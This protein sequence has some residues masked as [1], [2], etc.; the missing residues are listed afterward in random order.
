MSE[1]RI[2]SARRII[3]MD[4]A[5]PFATHVA[6]KDGQILAVGSRAEVAGPNA[7]IDERFAD[8]I[9]VPGFVEGHAHVL[10]GTLWKHVYVGAFDR[11]N[12]EGEIVTGLPST[13][14]IIE[15]L[16]A[17]ASQLGD[18][19]TP[20]NGWGFDPLHIEGQKL[21]RHD[22]DKVST[23]RPVLVHHASLHITVVNSVLLES[24]GFDAGTNIQGVAK[25]PDGTPSGEL[26]G[27]AAR[28]R[29]ARTMGG[30]PLTNAISVGDIARFAAAAKVQGITTIT[31][32]HSE[33]TDEIVGIYQEACTEDLPVRIVPLLGSAFY[34]T[35][36]A[37][38]RIASVKP[39][40]TARLRF[41]LVKIVVDGSIQGFTARLLAPGYHNGAPN[42]LWYV[43]PDDLKRI[44]SAFHK[45]GIQMHIHTN[46]NE[47]TE[48]A[49][50]AVE[51]ALAERPDADHRHT[52]QHC[53]MATE[54]QFARIKAL[55]LCVNLFSN[56]LYYWGEA[57]YAFTMGPE[58][59]Q[60]MNATATARRLGIPFAIHSD[61]P[62]TPL[63][64]LFTV[65]CA[66][67]RMSSEGRLIGPE[68]RIGVHEALHA[69]T[70][71]AAYTL[72]LD[73]EIGSVT[74][75]KRADFAV[76]EADP[77]EAKPETI[78]D[79]GIAATIVGGKVFG[80]GSA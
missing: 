52:L 69:V 66:V 76:L 45:E 19:E 18:A 42:G 67:N 5:R 36:A 72:K 1:T 70:L 17:A 77:L 11:K 64:P 59:A 58:R 35:D 20:L 4:A 12:P 61:A 40:S 8:K 38:E 47:A 43:A 29:I 53:Q 30:N 56:H 16:Q 41:G 60:R 39:L 73:R 79:I 80:A 55:G 26:Q 31:D 24:A 63:G 44:V 48:A 32:L 34:P 25:L 7:I 14:A 6:V 71:G 10:E 28:L 68:Q 13:D 2:F 33:L 37:I 50:E 62:V 78:K 75:G 9:L 23:T 54:E 27:I 22:L 46:G 3:T 49:I 57:H 15:R 51:A 21:T 65:W 74:P